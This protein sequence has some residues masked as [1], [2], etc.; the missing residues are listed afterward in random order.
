MEIPYKSIQYNLELSEWGLDFDRWRMIDSEDI[1]WCNYQE[2]EG[3]RI[4][5]FGNLIFGDFRPRI[6]GLNLEVYPV[7]IAKAIYQENN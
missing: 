4:S 2:N 1:Y 7:G 5:K 3:Q 6:K